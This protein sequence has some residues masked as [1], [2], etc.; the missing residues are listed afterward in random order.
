MNS[1]ASAVKNDLHLALPFVSRL[2]A[3]VGAGSGASHAT[4]RDALNRLVDATPPPSDLWTIAPPS[5]SGRETALSYQLA[6]RRGPTP[7]AMD[8]KASASRAQ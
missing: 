2:P 1:Y 4:D 5:S 7:G 6:G 3:V 8:R